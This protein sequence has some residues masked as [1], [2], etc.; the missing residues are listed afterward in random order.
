MADVSQAADY[1][2]LRRKG[3]FSMRT[4]IQGEYMMGGSRSAA[5]LLSIRSEALQSWADPWLELRECG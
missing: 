2:S 1:K 3:R 5:I 4:M